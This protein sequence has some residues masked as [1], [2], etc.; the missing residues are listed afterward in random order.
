[1]KRLWIGWHAKL[2]RRKMWTSSIA[3]QKVAEALTKGSR[4][5]R[6]AAESPS[7]TETKKEAA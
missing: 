6:K 3:I 1:M 5:Q 2:P 7:E 4:M